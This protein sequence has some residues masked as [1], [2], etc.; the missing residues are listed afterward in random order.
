M[1]VYLVFRVG[2]YRHECAGVFSTQELAEQTARRCLEEEH[3][4]YHAYEILQFDLDVELPRHNQVRQI[5]PFIDEPPLICC[6]RKSG[7]IIHR[8]DE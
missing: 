5:D 7:G 6:F 1:I 4:D 3:D 8:D 2:V